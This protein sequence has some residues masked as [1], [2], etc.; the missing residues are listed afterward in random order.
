VD[1]LPG[2]SSGR[3]QGK[4]KRHATK[5]FRKIWTQKKKAES[6]EGLTGFAF[7]APLPLALFFS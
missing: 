6:P 1:A 7:S 3:S 2:S 5:P 4:K